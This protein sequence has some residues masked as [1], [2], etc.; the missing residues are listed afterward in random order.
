M[1]RYRRRKGLARLCYNVTMK[2][3]YEI[4]GEDT[5][6][7]VRNKD[8]WFECLI[9]TADLPKLQAINCTWYANPT[10]KSK[11]KFYANAKI[12]G[13]TAMMHRIITNA[14]RGYE[15]HHIDNN[16]L[17][18]R[19]SNFEP[20]VT[21]LYNMRQKDPGRDWVDYDERR[22]FGSEYRKERAIAAQVQSQFGLGRQQLHR[23][24]K[25]TTRGS[26]AA[27]AYRDAIKNAGIR[28][29]EL[30]MHDKP[31]PTRSGEPSE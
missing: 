17:N 23:I 3:K 24:R 15:T 13:T 4:R 9:S 12:G 16:G 6:I 14:R 22:E 1:M 5:V 30:L 20:N 29:L 31:D 26:A 11:T 21:H 8:R 28:S 7:H 19:R 18:N 25:G 2:N 27:I 10:R